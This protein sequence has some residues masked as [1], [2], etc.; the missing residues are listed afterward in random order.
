MKAKNP[1][2]EG[3]AQ[4]VG[5]T[6]PN[7]LQVR[8]AGLSYTTTLTWEIAVDKTQRCII[9]FLLLYLKSISSDST[10]NGRQQITHCSSPEGKYAHY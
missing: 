10:T 1:W 9:M 2:G 6:R 8:E 4:Q 3:K 7:F 5:L